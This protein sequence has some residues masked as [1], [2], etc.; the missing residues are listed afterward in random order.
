L[1]A[2]GVCALAL[3]TG[4]II[5]HTD[6]GGKVR[7]ALNP[8]YGPSKVARGLFGLLCK[9]PPGLTLHVAIVNGQ[10]G[11]VNVLDGIPFAVVALDMVAGRI[12]RL[13]SLSILANY[14]MFL[15]G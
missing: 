2:R 9:A 1:C 14:N 7:A 13:T 3:L 10:P 15:L 5:L 8:I 4:D 6:G 12:R 11:L